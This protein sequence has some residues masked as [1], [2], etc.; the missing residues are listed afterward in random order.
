MNQIT[1]ELHYFVSF[2]DTIQRGRRPGYDFVVLGSKPKSSLQRY[3][4]RVYLPA[5]RGGFEQRPIPLL[6]D[7]L[8]VLETEYTEERTES[9]SSE[10]ATVTI[11]AL[12]KF[13]V[14][15]EFDRNGRHPHYLMLEARGP[16]PT[17]DEAI[18][19]SILGG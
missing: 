15:V 19:A 2:S 4:R 9:D 12:C 14:I 17:R 13:W 16:F 6:S 5:D 7:E 11:T 18:E 1:E 8:Y 10:I 3:L